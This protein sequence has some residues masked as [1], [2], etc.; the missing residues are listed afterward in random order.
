MTREGNQPKKVR[1][2]HMHGLLDVTAGRWAQRLAVPS[3]IARKGDS[4]PALV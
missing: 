1:T 2:S 3:R 4:M